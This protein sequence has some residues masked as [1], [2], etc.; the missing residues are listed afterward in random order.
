MK[1]TAVI[2]GVMKMR[3]D[4]IYGKYKSRKIRGTEAAELLGVSERT[5]RR[6]RGRYEEEGIEG[7]RDKRL[8]R[9]SSKRAA[10][11]EVEQLTKLYEER[12][13][14]FSV[15][16]FHEFAQREN[17]LQYGYTWTKK[18]L[19]KAQ[20]IKP[21]KRG[22][23][24][25]LRR[26][27]RPMV[28]MMLHQDGSTH[29]WIS[30]LNEKWD[31]IITLDDATSIITSGFFVEEE[32][33]QSSFDGLRETIET[34]GL[35]C[36]L[37]TDRGSHYWYTPEAGGKVSKHTLT[38]VG[39]ALKQLGIR[40]IA[41]YSPQARGRS[42][43][44]FGT[45]QGRLPKE[46]ALQGIKTMEEANRYLKEVYIPRHNTQFGVAPREKES[47]YI[48][49]VAQDQL[50]EILCMHEEREV[51]KDNTIR[52]K[53]MTLQIPKNDFRHHYVRT[54][55]EVRDYGKQGIGVFYGHMCIGKY[56]ANGV[57]VYGEKRPE[58]QKK[59]MENET[60]TNLKAMA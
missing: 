34:Y 53:G 22:G 52:Y 6:K 44:M 2:E 39:R 14:G 46:L 58:N 20:L 35:F 29:E 27:R 13:R 16:H 7:V 28:G 43:R 11:H 49:W 38:Q 48:K 36:S 60:K 54:K 10:D 18:T 40:H 19:E 1:K 59:K 9:R 47:A 30:G 12:Y 31:L 8:G 3:F 25:R 15:K 4:E 41:A 45:L 55:V 51:Q 5:F 37:Y 32:G 21:S 56:T 57:L 24:H 33:T 17:G 23:D 50:Q 26:E 42:E